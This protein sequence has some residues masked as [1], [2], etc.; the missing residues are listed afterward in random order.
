MVGRKRPL[1]WARSTPALSGTSLSVSMRG[2]GR[3]IAEVMVDTLATRPEARL[4]ALAAAFAQACGWPL[5]REVS[6]RAIARDGRLM[7]VASSQAWADQL[8][9][10]AP[11][12]LSRVNA[13]L[14]QE[15]ATSLEIR[16]GPVNR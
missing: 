1:P 15:V 6:L 9:P 8:Q 3:T 4:P 2:R 16:V 11:M 7:V 14:G 10:L 13:R 12:L 5:S